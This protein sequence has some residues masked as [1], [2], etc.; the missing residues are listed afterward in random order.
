MQG[1]EMV[2]ADEIKA[3]IAPVVA[4]AAAVV[5]GNADQY[6]NAAGFLK[7][8]KGAQKRVLDFFGPIKAAAHA[9]WK[10]TTEGEAEIM[11]PLT[12]AENM[13]KRKMI[14]YQ[15]EQERIRRAEQARLQAIEDERVRKEREKAE[16]AARIQREKEEAARAEQVRLERLAQQ[17]RSEAARARAQAAAEEAR[18]AAEAAAAKAAVREEKAA[19]VQSVPVFV[20][21]AAPVIK[22]QQIRTTWKARVIDGRAAVSAIMALP[23]WTAYIEIDAGQLN[24]FAARTQGKAALAGVEFYEESTLASSSK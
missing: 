17:V 1:N 20:A 18:K 4:Q 6:E 24:K 13:V 22:G 8:V 16:A 11:R 9:A 10:K 2:R 7:I 5:I 14:E 3:E 15:T 12:D 19:A 21:P 23:D